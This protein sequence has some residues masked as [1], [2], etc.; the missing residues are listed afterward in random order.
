MSSSVGS[1]I[2]SDTIVTAKLAQLCY[3]QGYKFCLRYPLLRE[4]AMEHPSTAA[5]W[6]C[7]THNPGSE[8]ANKILRRVPPKPNA[9]GSGL[10]DC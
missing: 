1:G 5:T 8:K 9:V 4:R 7:F 10:H 3:G 2:D 6:I